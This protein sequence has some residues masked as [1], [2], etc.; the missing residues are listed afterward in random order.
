MG[1]SKMTK[2]EQDK[3]IIEKLPPFT[4]TELKLVKEDL[5]RYFEEQAKV[6]HFMLLSNDI[7]YYTIFKKENILL[8]TDKARA[9]NFF[10]FIFKDRFLK[11]LGKP[12][13]VKRSGE[14]QVEIWIG[15][16]PFVLFNADSFFVE[17]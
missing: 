12:K 14:D 10:D 6:E 9:M 7:N 3:A 8:K 1:E 2:A 4:A 11:T 16:T 13:V 17:I 15:T 5:I